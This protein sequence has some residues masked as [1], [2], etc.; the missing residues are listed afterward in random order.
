METSDIDE[1]HE[2]EFKERYELLDKYSKNIK[3]LTDGRVK[4]VQSL[5]QILS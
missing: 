4:I 5:K 2:S 3:N 1:A